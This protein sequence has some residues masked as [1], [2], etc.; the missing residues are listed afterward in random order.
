V[1]K[2][3]AV[4]IG[5]LA[6]MLCFGAVAVAGIVPLVR[7]TAHV[8]TASRPS[9]TYTTTGSITPPSQYCL[10]GTTAAAYCVTLTPSAVCTGRVSLTVKLS[11]D[12]LLSRSNKTIKRTS[13]RLR[14]NCT[15][16]IKTGF[17]KKYFTSKHPYG[18]HASGTKVKV[19]FA[20]RYLGNVVLSAKSA[21][22]QTV[23]AKVK[24]P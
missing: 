13:G 11:R 4:L 21:R 9:Y 17:P 2:P 22:T 24:N 12:K 16:S 3:A 8:H 1:R 7:V 10:P 14:S 6:G 18:A 20:V 5:L 19:S 15:F 23:T